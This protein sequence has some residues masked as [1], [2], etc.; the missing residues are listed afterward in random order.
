MI[1]PRT[2]VGDIHA[3]LTLTGGFD[4]RSIHVDDS[5]VE[6]GLGLPG[7]NMDTRIIENVLQDLDLALVEAATEIAR[8]RRIGDATCP[9][10]VQEDLVGSE[11]LEV[12]QTSTVT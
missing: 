9:K 5:L 6:K 3:L 12:L 2:V 1:T 4:Q 8:R 11:Q 7:P 10:G